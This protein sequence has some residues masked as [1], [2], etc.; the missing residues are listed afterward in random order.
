MRDAIDEV[1]KALNEYQQSD[2]EVTLAVAA[3]SL[4]TS[5]EELLRCIAS[6]DP[7]IAEQVDIY[8][9]LRP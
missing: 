2:G 7:L 5:A 4:A 6:R 9:N 3:D 1:I 8:F